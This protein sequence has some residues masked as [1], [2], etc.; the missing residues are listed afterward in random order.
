MTNTREINENF[1]KKLIKKII[2]SFGYK[3]VK[4]NNF[5]DKYSDFILEASDSEKNDID[6]AIKLALCSRASLWSMIQSLKHISHNSIEGDIVECGVFSGGSLALISKYLNLYSLN[7]KIYGYDTFEKGFENPAI[8][9]KDTTINGKEI[10]ISGHNSTVKSNFFPTLGQVRK[11]IEN[12]SRN[13]QI[14]LK[15]I[16]GDILKTLKDEDNLPK[17]ISFLRL[18]TDLYSTTKFELQVLFPRLV[19]GGV[20][21]IDDYG[22][23]PGVQ[24]AVD[25]YFKEKNIWL[26]RV[27]LTTRLLI[28]E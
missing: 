17:K 3:I 18:D 24:N 1:F 7:F 25:E 13:N 6:E 28:K 2:S 5:N 19:S 27:D 4:I 20:L 14:D 22:M 23:F 16:K 11:N 26:H 21:H 15:L 12:Y 10:E 9:E 8:T